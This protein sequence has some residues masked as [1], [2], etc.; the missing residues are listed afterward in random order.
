MKNL[1]SLASLKLETKYSLILEKYAYAEELMYIP[2][3]YDDE[4]IIFFDSLFQMH[5][6]ITGIVEAFERGYVIPWNNFEE[7]EE[8]VNLSKNLPIEEFIKWVDEAK[9]KQY[10]AYL[11]EIN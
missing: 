10:K 4:I 11:N 7:T 8:S 3:E 5:L 6:K 2:V 9:A 1:N